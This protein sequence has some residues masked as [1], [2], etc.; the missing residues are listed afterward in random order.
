MKRALQ[1]RLLPLPAASRFEHVRLA[2]R[3]SKGLSR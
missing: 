2:L 1:A 3:L